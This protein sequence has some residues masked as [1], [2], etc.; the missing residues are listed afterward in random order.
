MAVLI[1]MLITKG[2]SI[3]GYFKL[4][5]FTTTKSQMVSKALNQKLE[6][7]LKIRQEAALS[8]TFPVGLFEA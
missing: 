4:C 3:F 8:Q 7:F 6:H 2:N 1:K 5:L